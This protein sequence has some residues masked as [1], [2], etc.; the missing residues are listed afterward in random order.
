MTVTDDPSSPLATPALAVV[1][2]VRNEAD[3][4]LPLVTE[5]HAA[6]A[7]RMAFEIVYVDDGSDDAT[8]ERLAQARQAF[9]CLRTVRHRVSCGQSQ[10]VATG[11]RLARAPL[12]A[13]L[14][15]DGQNDPADLPALVERWRATP[16]PARDRLMIAGWRTRRQDTWSRRAAS[17]L[18]NAIRARLL[19]DA[20]P[21]TGCGTKLFP[22]ALFLDLPYFDHM[23]RFLPALVL[24]AGGQVD[25]VA[26]NH[27]PRERGASKYSN[28]RR[29]LVGIPD[30]LGVMWLIRRGSRPIIESRP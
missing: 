11:V 19:G 13:T 18:A 5:I 7:G 21:D 8:P 4:I 16:Q 15:G 26:V 17:R 29:A 24:R 28:L 2:P 22:R 1:V 25:S 20:T 9:P 30:L 10:A 12:I 27:R 23:H 3:N 6:L 14:D